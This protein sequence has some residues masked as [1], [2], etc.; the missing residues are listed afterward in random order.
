MPNNTS[1]NAPAVPGQAGAGRRWGRVAGDHVVEEMRREGLE[2]SDVRHW[3]N[4]ER[5]TPLALAAALGQE[6]MFRPACTKA[7]FVGWP[8]QATRQ[9]EG[10]PSWVEYSWA[11]ARFGTSLRST[12]FSHILHLRVRIVQRDD[13]YLFT[14]IY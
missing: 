1:P 14:V 8:L 12:T 13:Y 10:L 9:P 7:P 11:D 3:L 6:R 4:A 5:L 2:D